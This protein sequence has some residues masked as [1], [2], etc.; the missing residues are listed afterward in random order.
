MSR[1][2]KDP[3]R[4]L[5][6]EERTQL[7]RLSRSRS[8][9]ASHVAR[10]KALL[11]VADGKSYTDAA[12]LVGYALGD[13]VAQLVARFNREGVAAVLPGH[14][15]GPEPRYTPAEREQILFEARRT[16]DRE[17]DG[18]A[19]WSLTTLQKSLRAKGLP[20][21]STY[22]IWCVLHEAGLSWQKSRTWC[23]TG[24]APRK[25]KAGVVMVSDADAEAKKT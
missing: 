21:V 3:L 17:Q 9:A 22:T 4:L 2:Q 5:T 20:H 1:R 7:E 23:E 15:G 14:A 11:A 18:T 10:A 16:P 8:E 12:C 19:T 25:R 13:S 24:T 6:E